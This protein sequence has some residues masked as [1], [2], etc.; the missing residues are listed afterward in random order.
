MSVYDFSVW[1]KAKSKYEVKDKI[2]KELCI[3]IL[4]GVNTHFIENGWPFIYPF[5]N[6]M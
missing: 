3:D 6:C 5:M 2:N 4:R 1:N